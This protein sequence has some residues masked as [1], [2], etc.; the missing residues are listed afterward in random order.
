VQC[1][2]R[3]S[4]RGVAVGSTELRALDP[5]AARPSVAASVK[6][7]ASESPR[8][9]CTALRCGWWMATLR[10]GY[11]CRATVVGCIEPTRPAR[12]ERCAAGSFPRVRR[13]RIL[14][15]HSESARDAERPGRSTR[16]QSLPRLQIPP[17]RTRRCRQTG[18]GS[19]AGCNCA[20]HRTSCTVPIRT[21][22]IGCCAAWRC[23]AQA[24]S[25]RPGRSPGRRVRCASTVSTN[26]L[27]G[28]AVR[29]AAATQ[30]LIEPFLRWCRLGYNADSR[31]VASSGTGRREQREAGS[32]R[33]AGS[34]STAVPAG[35]ARIRSDSTR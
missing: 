23:R 22:P 24:R 9:C 1:L 7:R 31:P 19:G 34:A 10:D 35:T 12:G 2:A 33:S 29:S 26:L 32:Y 17:R 6:D 30:R 11:S 21:S 18:V 25:T 27:S 20:N 14:G 3:D 5:D 28:S 16:T 15:E 13:C 8:G 4:V